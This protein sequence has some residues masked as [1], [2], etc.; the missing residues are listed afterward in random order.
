MYLE[1]LNSIA[2]NFSISEKIKPRKCIFKCQMYE[3]SVQADILTQVY[4]RIQSPKNNVT[5]TR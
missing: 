4:P 1:S 2:L 5:Y 3:L